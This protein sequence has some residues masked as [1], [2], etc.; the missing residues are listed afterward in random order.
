MPAKLALNYFS[1]GYGIHAG[2]FSRDISDDQRSPDYLSRASWFPGFLVSTTA[3]QL[4]FPLKG[5]I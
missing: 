5:L 1:N 3:I 2:Y 4:I